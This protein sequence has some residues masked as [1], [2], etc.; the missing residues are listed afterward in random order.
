[1]Q[2]NKT[3][4]TNMYNIQKVQ[5]FYILHK[6]KIDERTKTFSFSEWYGILGKSQKECQARSHL[7]NIKTRDV[8]YAPP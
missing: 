6:G 2:N 7:Y 8:S 3:L 1:M 5:S 4:M